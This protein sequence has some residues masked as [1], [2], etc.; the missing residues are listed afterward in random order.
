VCNDPHFSH[1]IFH[2]QSLP[3][4]DE[5]ATMLNLQRRLALAVDKDMD[6][7]KKRDQRGKSSVCY[8]QTNFHT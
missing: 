4:A 6:V 1:C 3:S 8:L 5:T 7:S 2:A